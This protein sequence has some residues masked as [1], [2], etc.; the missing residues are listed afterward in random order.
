M[1]TQISLKYGKGTIAITV[2]KK[3]LMGILEPAD[4][5]GVPDELEEIRNALANPTESEPLSVLAKGKKNVVILVSDIT[6]PSP[7]HKMLPPIVEELNKAGVQDDQITVVFGLGFHRSHTKD[8]QEQLIGKE[9]FARLRCLDHDRNDCIHIGNTSR[10]TPVEIFRPVAEADFLIATGNIEFHYN[11]GYTAGSKAL[12][13]GVCSQRS[14]EANHQ[15]M[16]Y[17]G[18]ETGKLEGNPMREDIEEAGELAGI[19]FIVNVILNSKKEI[20]K[21]VAGHRIKAHREGVKWVD[22]MYKRPISQPADIVIACC[23]GSPKDINLYQAQKG[24]ENASY[25]ARKGGIIILVAECPEHF[26]EPL[27]EDW[28]TRAESVDDPIKWVQEK[29]VLGAHK[30]V[31]FCQ[32]LKEKE[33]YL[34]SSMPDDM[35]KSCFFQPA[36][37]VEEALEMALQKLG[38]DAKILVMPNANTTVPFIETYGN[39]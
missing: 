18:T 25:A 23:G 21:A 19:K 3:N 38:Q 26:G 9:M 1:S 22:K 11:A 5:P 4:L 7:S 30:A 14:I 39:G 31:V 17:P 8:E 2:P 28:I 15:T 20:V 29:F 32:V 37:S 12:F 33:G 10:G 27:F 24:F 16:I 36:A 13:P 34:V 6:R 35:V